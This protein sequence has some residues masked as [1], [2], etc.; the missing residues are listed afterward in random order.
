MNRE[1]QTN[2]FWMDQ[3]QYTCPPPACE[4][5]LTQKAIYDALLDLSIHFVRIQHSPTGNAQA[6]APVEARLGIRICKNL[7][8]QDTRN[9]RYYLYT[10]PG[11]CRMEQKVLGAELGCGHLSFGAP[12]QMWRLLRCLPGSASALGL[13][14]DQKKEVSYLMDARAAA[15]PYIAFHPCDNTTSIRLR[16]MDFIEK[17]L[18][19]CAHS[20]H[21][22]GRS[23]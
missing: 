11:D 23:L 21:L 18:P 10:L 7:F 13:L 3:T 14:F 20:L 1:A 17:F 4:C 8:L 16:T 6:C 9:G 19:H 5:G 2:T 12:E 22:I 15:E